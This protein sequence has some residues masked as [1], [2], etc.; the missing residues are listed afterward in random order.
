MPKDIPAGAAPVPNDPR[1]GVRDVA[2]GETLAVREF[3]GERD[4]KGIAI[5]PLSARWI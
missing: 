3:P 5:T 1:V 2:E 4:Q